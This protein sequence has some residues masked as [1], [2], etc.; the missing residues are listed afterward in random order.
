MICSCLCRYGMILIFFTSQDVWSK[1]PSICLAFKV[2]PASLDWLL[3]LP[4]ESWNH[5]IQVP[6]INLGKIDT[7]TVPSLLSGSPHFC[8][9]PSSNN[10]QF[11]S[12][13]SYMDLVRTKPGILYFWLLLSR[14]FFFPYYTYYWSLVGSCKN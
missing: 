3:R 10:V 8:F 12:N 5:F 11:S 13:R 14:E 4:D 6:I 1:S 7:S 9:F 2:F